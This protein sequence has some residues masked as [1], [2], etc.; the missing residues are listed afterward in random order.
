M[1]AIRLPDNF[2]LTLETEDI[3]EFVILSAASSFLF[4]ELCFLEDDVGVL[5]DS[6]SFKS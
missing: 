2:R 3:K 6:W 5:T 4:N 1:E